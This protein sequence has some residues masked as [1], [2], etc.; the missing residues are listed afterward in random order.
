MQRIGWILAVLI[1]LGWLA[2]E[3]PLQSA[4]TTDQMKVQTCW[5]RTVSGWENASQWSF[6][7]TTPRPDFHPVLLVLMQ[8][9]FVALVVFS[10]LFT[11]S[12]L[13]AKAKCP[14]EKSELVGEDQ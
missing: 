13:K 6:E 1:S 2:S 9:T 10:N 5:R 3:I 11:K 12:N 14:P 4:S 8:C 7:D